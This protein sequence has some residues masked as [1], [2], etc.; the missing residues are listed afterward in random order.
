MARGGEDKREG[1]EWSQ[2]D[3]CHYSCLNDW[4]VVSPKYKNYFKVTE[5][6]LIT[7]RLPAFLRRVLSFENNFNHFITQN[8]YFK[9]KVFYTHVLE[10][11]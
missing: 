11:I 6:A 1:R 2:R 10:D 3:G 5:S 9:V 8:K 4:H 7:E